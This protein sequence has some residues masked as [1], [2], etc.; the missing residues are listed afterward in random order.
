MLAP[1]PP[2]AC[3]CL[4][5]GEAGNPDGALQSL[6]QPLSAV[7]TEPA[8]RTCRDGHRKPLGK[9]G[10]L[11]HG[12]ARNCGSCGGARGRRDVCVAVLVGAQHQTCSGTPGSR[13]LSC[14][15]LLFA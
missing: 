13:W 2:E 8:A 12:E 4:T 6:A 5:K 11:F 3:S 10:A 9:A 1:G 7:K 14:E 15:F